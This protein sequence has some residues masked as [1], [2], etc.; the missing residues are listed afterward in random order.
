V[1]VRRLDSARAL[2]ELLG[3]A[4][5][6]RLLD[7]I[8]DRDLRDLVMKTQSRLRDV[9]AAETAPLVRSMATRG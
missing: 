8:G 1:I 2:A 6:G 9:E 3:A 7:E 5:V 4:V